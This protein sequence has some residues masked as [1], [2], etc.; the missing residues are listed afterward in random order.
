MYYVLLFIPLGILLGIITTLAQGRFIFYPFLYIGILLPSLIVEVI[1]AT[2]SG[3]SI[4]VENIL[5]GILIT[6][7]TVLILKMQ[8]PNRLRSSTPHPPGT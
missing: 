4:L 3:R 2:D 6:A 8:I 5:L 1:L 7:F